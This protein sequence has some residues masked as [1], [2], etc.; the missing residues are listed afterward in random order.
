MDKRQILVVGN[1][2][3]GQRFVDRFLAWDPRGTCDITVIGEESPARLRPR[4][5]DELVQRHDRGRSLAWST[6]GC[7]TGDR[8]DYRFGQHVAEVDTAQ[9]EGDARRWFDARVRRARHRHRVGTVRAADP[10]PRTG[11]L[12]RVSH[13]RRPRRDQV[14]G[15]RRRAGPPASSSVAAC[16][17]WK[18]RTLSAS[19]GLDVHV[20]EMAPVPDAAAARRGRRTDARPVGRLARRAAALRCGPRSIH[21]RRRRQRGRPPDVGRDCIPVRHRGLLG[22]RAPS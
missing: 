10:R 8:V 3:V 19:L 11:R 1:G 15:D 2:M 14:V 9:P 13:D 12:L 16:S 22:R 17:A 6:T 5:V 4:R 7:S 18:Q 20:V 21:R